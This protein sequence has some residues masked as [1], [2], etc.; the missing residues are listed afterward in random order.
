MVI[1]P[2]KFESNSHAETQVYKFLKDCKDL[3]WIGYF[4][5]KLTHLEADLILLI[6]NKGIV[7]VEI[8]GIEQSRVVNVKD[9]NSIL[10]R[11]SDE[12]IVEI[13]SPAKRA[14]KYKYALLNM[15]KQQFNKNPLIISGVCYPYVSEQAFEH[16]NLKIICDRKLCLLK[17]D[18]KDAT[19]FENRIISMFD[20]YEESGPSR[21]L[22]FF[23]GQILSQIRGMFENRRFEEEECKSSADLRHYSKLY[24]VSPS[25]SSYMDKIREA[26]NLW[27]GGTKIYIIS[28]PE[29]IEK[30]QDY[31]NRYIMEEL[32]P[33][34]T[35]Y[36]RFLLK[37]NGSYEN[38]S[39]NLEFHSIERR[40]I[41]EG[42][43]ESFEV[44]D[45]NCGE[46]KNKLMLLSEKTIFNFE[47]YEIEHS[48]VDADIIVKAG[49]GTGKTTAMISR[50]AYLAHTC[51]YVPEDIPKKIIMITF[52]NKAAQ[53]MKD[54]LQN[55]YENLYILT[56]NIR[57]FEIIASIRKMNISTIHSLV[58]KIL[59][60]YSWF[61]GY[62]AEIKVI[63]DNS[64]YDDFIFAKLDSLL[65]G[66]Y[67]NLRDFIQK[68]NVSFYH[69]K[70]IIITLI[71]LLKIRNIDM[72]NTELDVGQIG[73]DDKQ[74]SE[75]HELLKNLI[76]EVDEEARTSL[77][78]K[79]L[80]LLSDLVI[81]IKRLVETAG[82]QLKQIK[83]DLEYVFI[84]EFQDTDDTQIYVLARFKE[85]LGF[86]IF[87]V[88]DIKQCIYRFRGAEDNAF[89]RLREETPNTDWVELRLNKNYRTDREL[90]KKL[91][92][93]F[94]NWSKYNL[95][96]D[97]S[98]LVGVKEFNQDDVHFIVKEYNDG[99][100][101]KEENNDTGSRG[102]NYDEVLIETIKEGIEY[103]KNDSSKSHNNTIALLVREN[104]QVERIK[105]ICK[106]YKI[107]VYTDIGGNLYKIKPTLDFYLLVR[108]LKTN[109]L[110]D[111]GV[112][113]ALSS[114]ATNRVK[115][116]TLAALKDDEKGLRELITADLF[117]G[118]WNYYCDK[119]KFEPVLK[120]VKEI[121]DQT[122]PWV[123]YRDEQLELYKDTFND[124][125]P[126]AKYLE[127]FYRENLYLLIEKVTRY[128]NT[129][130]LTLS[131][132]EGFLK[133]KIIAG[134]EDSKEIDLEK[135]DNIKIVCMT[136]HKAKGLEFDYV[137]LPD[138]E[139]KFKSVK[140]VG[141]VDL[142]VLKDGNNK[143]KMGYKLRLKKG[144]SYDERPVEVSSLFYKDLL[145]D[146]KTYRLKEEV[147]ILYVALTRAIKRIVM[148]KNKNY[149]FSQRGRDWTDELRSWHDFI[150]FFG[151]GLL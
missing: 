3:N 123:N 83:N 112:L 20:L 85:L 69:L 62:G 42:L 6:P 30:A 35:V 106:R 134:E 45:G 75:L 79:D 81:Q 5:Y 137:I 125:A 29:I 17:E 122:K 21:T 96:I 95:L 102:S 8:K 145:K 115:K 136:V 144:E 86:R 1:F 78:E 39:F 101:E 28:I 127:D 59:D 105:N 40:E 97:Y 18:F 46:N 94:E 100:D 67:S 49:A 113:Y 146:E 98:E 108:A 128:F 53:N 57:Y 151:R 38:T 65:Q 50:I 99:C 24:Y 119:L 31:F 111:L 72:K 93:L 73:E 89:E 51:N 129:E 116:N 117:N 71:N 60:K 47:Q 138:I 9:N 44:V 92:S 19:S 139:T 66:R 132:L 7:I 147:R 84:D 23:D 43:E 133:S 148:L 56:R 12:K 2:D 26:L 149:N 34:G 91:A 103:L 135:I 77:I 143:F 27:L 114:Y 48:P 15:I 14:D 11:D 109:S 104:K 4:N 74:Y 52:T 121:I 120:V 33:K 126:N 70:K 150:H 87:A 25:D 41:R 124:G 118:N 16:L 63:E 141:D 82:D 61:F 88:G 110:K 90:L 54:R 37:E 10:Y 76:K 13:F 130:Y 36:Q 55:Y 32:I 80:I 68:N 58:K 64:I 22:D 131:R 142:V 140:G 107:F